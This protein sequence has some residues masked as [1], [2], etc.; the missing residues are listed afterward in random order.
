MPYTYKEWNGCCILK[1]DIAEIM[2]KVKKAEVIV[3]ASEI[4][5]YDK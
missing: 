4:Y 1:D 5:Y 2:D 3:Y